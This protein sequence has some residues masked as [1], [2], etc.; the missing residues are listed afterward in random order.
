MPDNLIKYLPGVPQATINKLYGSIR[1]ARNAAPEI[2]AGVIQGRHA[3]TIACILLTMATCSLQRHHSPNVHRCSRT[4]YVSL[5]RLMIAA[6][7]TTTAFIS[8]ILAFFMP[9]F[10]LGDT[11][12]AVDGKNV[13]GERTTDA[14][15]GTSSTPINQRAAGEEV[16][17]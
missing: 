17:R 3:L 12:N 8:L 4:L 7:T 14:T 11:H 9:N 10:F 2:R 6:H 16:V 13:A 15:V 5:R 1:T